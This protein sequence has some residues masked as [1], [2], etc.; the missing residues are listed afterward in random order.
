MNG[1]PLHAAIVHIPLVLALVVPVVLAYLTLRAFR[2]GASRKAWAVIVA[3]QAVIVGVGVAALQTGE[4][5]EHRVEAVVSEAALETHEERAELFVTAAGALLA[6]TLLGLAAPRISRGVA[7]AAL[8][9]SIAVAGLGT[10]AGH[11][12]GT[13]VYKEG[14]AAAVQAQAS[15]ATSPRRDKHKDKDRDHDDD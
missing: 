13:L 11:A 1:L 10:A 12:G 3:L 2:G 15:R 4:A 9:L 6:L 8:I 5:E 14:A 7:P